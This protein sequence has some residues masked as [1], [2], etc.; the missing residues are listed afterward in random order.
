[1]IEEKSL[2]EFV[3][4]MKLVGKL[5]A[6]KRTGWVRQFHMENPESVAGHSFRT[7]MIGMLFSDLYNSKKEKPPIDTERLMRLA[8]LH[9]VHEAIMGDWDDTIKKE[10]GMDQFK[11]EEAKTI[12]ETIGL[13]PE[14]LRESY[15]KLWDELESQ[16]TLESRLVK[17][18]DRLE[19]SLQAVEYGRLGLEKDK[20]NEWLEYDDTQIEQEDLSKMLKKLIA[21]LN[22]PEY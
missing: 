11:K 1:M 18:I 2:D 14:P 5:K 15:R 17:Q 9:D 6:V 16:E 7:A 20:L 13:L 8:L 3:Q 19:C 22:E 4:F 21:E 10:R 12:Q